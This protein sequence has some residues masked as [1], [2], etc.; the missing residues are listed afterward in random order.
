MKAL[1]VVGQH[2]YGDPARGLGYEYVN[3]LPALTQLGYAVTHFESFDR[4]PYRD[5]A[6]MNRRLLE[7]I[8][9]IEPDLVFCVLMGYEIW[10]ETLDRI[11][12][13]SRALVLNW[14]TDDSWKYEQYS[15]FIAPHVDCY[16]TTYPEALEKARN[17]GLNNVALTQWAASD[18]ALAPPL[19]GSR[20]RYRVSFIGSAYGNRRAH[21]DDL[22]RR[23]IEV[24]CFG[25][26][27]PNGPVPSADVPRIMRE[28]AVCL[29]FGDS[30]THVRG[31]RPYRSRQ[32]KAR[33]FEVPGAGG[34]LLT[35]SA[36]HLSDYY[37]SGEEIETFDSRDELAQKLRYY[38]DR[39]DAR[40]RIARAG[41]ERTRREHTYNRRFAALLEEATRVRATSSLAPAPAL[42][43]DESFESICARHRVTPLLRL[44]RALISAPSRLL[45]GARRGPR[46]ARRLLFELSWRLGGARTYSAAGWPGRAFYRES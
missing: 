12:R 26:G 35:E 44:V 8:E 16:A 21:I 46:A 22:R 7:T 36:A 24:D 31:L 42:L 37:R 2:N 33:V 39:P 3:F 19:P 17:D 14:G 29:N 6:D 20:C 30:A 1:C 10:T 38:L 34:F 32:I 13:L 15:R 11:R 27:W 4:T 18:A 25:Y 41:H 40:D 45:F 43:A 28:S 9:R 5:F 23:G